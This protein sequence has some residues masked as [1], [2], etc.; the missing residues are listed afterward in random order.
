MIHLKPNHIQQLRRK[1]SSCRSARHHTIQ[2]TAEIY[3]KHENILFLCIYVFSYLLIKFF[4][5]EMI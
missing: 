2:Q 4:D 1:L 5:M 3:S